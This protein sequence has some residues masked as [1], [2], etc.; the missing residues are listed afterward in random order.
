[1]APG[2][3]YWLVLPTWMHQFFLRLMGIAVQPLQ[4]APRKIYG[5]QHIDLS[6]KLT[7]GGGVDL[8]VQSCARPTVVDSNGLSA[9]NRPGY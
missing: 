7:I 8:L 1:M 4:N 9:R 2:W 6:G 3:L 5:F